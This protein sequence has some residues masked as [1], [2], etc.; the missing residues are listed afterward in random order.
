MTSARRTKGLVIAFAA[1]FATTCIGWAQAAGPVGTAPPQQP[2]TKPSKPPNKAKQ[3]PR[4]PA[5]NAPKRTFPPIVERSLKLGRLATF[6]ATRILYT[7]RGEVRQHIV[8]TPGAL[9]VERP[10]SVVIQKPNH[11]SVYSPRQRTVRHVD[12]GGIERPLEAALRNLPAAASLNVTPSQAVG[13][14]SA[15]LVEIGGP[16]TSAS[17]TKVWIDDETG[18]VL[19]IMVNHGTSPISGFRLEDLDYRYVPTPADF[20]DSFGGA[21]VVLPREDLARVAVAAGVPAFTIPDGTSGLTLTRAEK[22]NKAGQ[23]VLHQSFHGNKKTVS[24]F[25]MKGAASPDRLRQASGAN[26][27]VV[28]QLEGFGVVLIGNVPEAELAELG[29][30]V[31]R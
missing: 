25:V 17:G 11:R 9:R 24:L 31:G 20:D 12:G 21:T 7:P 16:G 19:A 28:F 1:L 2:N 14:R 13:G 22:L 10:E 26:N 15:S 6:A 29:R 23:V 8:Y 27:F 18:V 5:A 30:H 4:K 3:K